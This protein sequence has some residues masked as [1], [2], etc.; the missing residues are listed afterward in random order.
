MKTETIKLV[1]LAII[2]AALVANLVMAPKAQRFSAFVPV[3]GGGLIVADHQT[4]T[5][6]VFKQSGDQVA[7]AWVLHWY[8]SIQYD[9]KL[10]ASDSASR[11]KRVII[12]PIDA[13]GK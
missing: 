3:N 9:S 11:V 8:D 6:K 10:P 2:A 7:L 13:R 12:D 4:G 5:T 1:L